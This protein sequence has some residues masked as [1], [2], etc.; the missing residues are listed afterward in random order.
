MPNPPISGVV[1]FEEALLRPL[2]W[3]FST[4]P[5]ARGHLGCALSQ[6]NSSFIAESACYAYANIAMP[7]GHL[8]PHLVLNL[9][10]VTFGNLNEQSRNSNVKPLN[11]IVQYIYDNFWRYNSGTKGYNFTLILRNSQ[12]NL[13]A[14]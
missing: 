11:V 14:V 4:P 8:L 5:R 9:I 3:S 6:S 13:I 7:P 2:P 12:Y 10:K 1:I